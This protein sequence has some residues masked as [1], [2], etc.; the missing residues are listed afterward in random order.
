MWKNEN[1]IFIFIFSF[2]K[3]IR[4]PDIILM[5]GVVVVVNVVL[6][7]WISSNFATHNSLLL[8]SSLLSM[9]MWMG[10]VKKKFDSYRDSIDTFFLLI[11]K[12]SHNNNRFQFICFVLLLLLFLSITWSDCCRNWNFFCCWNSF[13]IHFLFQSFFRQK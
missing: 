7:I 6:G 9:S 10:K 1:E 3:K 11:I 8:S 4:V 12:C 2:S 13:L 5:I